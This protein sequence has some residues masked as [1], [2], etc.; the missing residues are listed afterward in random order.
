MFQHHRSSRH[1]GRRH[2]RGHGPRDRH[3]RRLLCSRRDG[4]RHD[5]HGVHLPL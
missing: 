2:A 5:R 3:A 4:H 1:D